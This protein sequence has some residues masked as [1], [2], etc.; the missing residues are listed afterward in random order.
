VHSSGEHKATKQLGVTV[1]ICTKM[2]AGLLTTA[3]DKKVIKHPAA[4][5]QYL[6]FNE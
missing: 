5:A 4:G 1:L 6:Y 2:P 3:F